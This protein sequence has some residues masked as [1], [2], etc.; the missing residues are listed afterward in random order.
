MK[1]II[2]LVL[3]LV[4][5]FSFAACAKTAEEAPK[6]EPG[7]SVSTEQVLPPEISE[8]LRA[9]FDKAFEG[10][11]GVHLTPIAYFG[12]TDSG[13][14]FLARVSFLGEEAPETFMLVYLTED[15]S[16]IPLLSRM[17]DTGVPT[18]MGG[19]TETGGWGDPESPKVTDE[20]QA[21]FDKAFE[22]RDGAPFIPLALVSQQVV[23]GMNYCFFCQTEK[24]SGDPANAF[25]YIYSDLDGGAEITDIVPLGDE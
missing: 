3:A 2:A 4:M 23:A 21:V 17:A 12:E 14:A 18:R 22:G 5:A 6:D 1:K 8:E 20:L 16:G 9:D 11:P 24:E 15:D 13:S 10:S 7:E 19:E 25:V